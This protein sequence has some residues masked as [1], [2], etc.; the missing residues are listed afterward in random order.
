MYVARL[1]FNATT[2][3][4]NYLIEEKNNRPLVPNVVCKCESFR[5]THGGSESEPHNNE[6]PWVSVGLMEHGGYKSGS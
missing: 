2:I 3:I 1:I 6:T 5:T 4:M